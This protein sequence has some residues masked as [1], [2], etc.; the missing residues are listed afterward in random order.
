M[1]DNCQKLPSI[2]DDNRVIPGSNLLI[3]LIVSICIWSFQL[4]VDIGSSIVARGV[5]SLVLGYLNNLVIELALL[6]QVQ[7]DVYYV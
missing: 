1:I 6:I 2:I 4:G 5:V 7:D 3:K